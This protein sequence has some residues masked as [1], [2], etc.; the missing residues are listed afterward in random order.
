MRIIIR[1]F[2]LLQSAMAPGGLNTT[3][4]WSRLLLTS[5]GSVPQFRVYPH[6]V[7]LVAFLGGGLESEM[8]S[9]FCGRILE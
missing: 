5:G 9:V 8:D 2:L 6:G 3:R 4:W 1:A 7:P